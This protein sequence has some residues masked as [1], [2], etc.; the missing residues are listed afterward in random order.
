[1]KPVF[2]EAGF[3]DL[4]HRVERLER[5]EKAVQVLVSTVAVLVA[6]FSRFVGTMHRLTDTPG[7]AAACQVVQSVI[8]VWQPP[9]L[10]LC[11]G[12]GIPGG[13]L[14]LD[15]LPPSASPL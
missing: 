2:N 3:N 13:P 4:L 14:P 9:S 8:S 10:G 11:R 15:S 7:I 6:C 5:L 12:W 1:M